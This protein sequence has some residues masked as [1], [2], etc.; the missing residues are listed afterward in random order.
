MVAG[1]YLAVTR[2]MSWEAVYV[3]IPVGLLTAMILYVNQ[4]PDRIADAATGKRTLIVRWPAGRVVLGYAVV[5]GVAFGLIVVGPVLGITPW[6]SLL[7]IGG[8]WWAV[9]TYRPLRA[10]YDAPYALIPVMQSNIVAHLATGL[11]LVAGY[12][13]AAAL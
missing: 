13:L 1:T 2:Q 7:G 9:Q 4:I 11:L 12:L 8:A 5:C 6:W 10:R 3:S